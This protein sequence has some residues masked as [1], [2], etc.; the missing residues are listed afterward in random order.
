M[1]ERWKVERWKAGPLSVTPEFTRCAGVKILNHCAGACSVGTALQK[2][3]P[4]PFGDPFAG[5][6]GFISMSV[7]DE[8]LIF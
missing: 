1:S 4:V 6:H 5:R 3:N 2:N 7:D 8:H